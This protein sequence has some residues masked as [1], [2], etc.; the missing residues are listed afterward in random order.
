VQ[1]YNF[2]LKVIYNFRFFIKKFVFS[3]TLGQKRSVFAHF[4]L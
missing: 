3:C 1:R 2:Y 4:F